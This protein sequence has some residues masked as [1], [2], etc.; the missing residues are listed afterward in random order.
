MSDSMKH[1]LAFSFFPVSAPPSSGGEERLFHIFHELSKTHKVTLLSSGFLGG[2]E[3]RVQHGANFV[4]RRIPKDEHFTR[5][6]DRLQ[7]YA[8]KGDIS[9][10]CVG[11]CGR[12][13]TLLHRAYIEEYSQADVIVHNFPFTIGYDLFLGLDS[14]VRIYNS[15]NCESKLY[16]MLHDDSSSSFIPDLV[17][18]L[19][20][21]LL[22]H[23]DCVLYCSETDLAEFNKIAPDGKFHTLSAPNGLTPKRTNAAS[24]AES[25]LSAVFIGSAHRPNVEAAQLLVNVVAPALPSVL[26]NIIGAC[27]PKGS[28]APNVRRHGV[29]TSEEKE[30][31]MLSADIAVN[32]M[33]A[34]SG[35][36]L[37]MLEFL[38]YGIPVISTKVGVRGLSLVPGKEYVLAEQDCFSERIRESLASPDQLA[39]VAER[40]Q[41]TAL[42]KYDWREI[43][44]PVAEF[45]SSFTKSCSFLEGALL[46]INDYNSFETIGGGGT[47]T[48]GL[49]KA[50]SEQSPVLF[51]CF[52][53]NEECYTQV[54]SDNIVSICIPKS[55]KLSRKIDTFDAMC[56]VS[57]AD[58][59]TARYCLNEDFF[60][61]VYNIV[62]R[63]AEMIQCE[64][65]YLTG[66]PMHFGDKFIYSSHNNEAALKRDL[67]KDHPEYELL[68]GTVEQ[69][70]KRAVENAAA[71]IATS[72]DDAF[73][74]TRG[75]SRGGPVWVLGNGA[76]VRESV[77]YSNLEPVVVASQRSV[78]FLG[79]AHMPNINA[80][81]K[82]FEEVV[83]K[84]PEITFHII[85]SVCS[86]LEKNKHRNVVLWG[87]LDEGKKNAVMA[88]CTLAVNPVFEGSGSNVKLADYIGSGLHV[89]CTPF[90]ARGYP[91]SVAEHITILPFDEFAKVIPELVET[92]TDESEADRRNRILYYNDNLSM[93][94]RSTKLVSFVKQ[95]RKKRKKV[96]A[97]TYRYSGT[98]LGGA[99]EHLLKL[100][101]YLDESGEFDIDVVSPEVTA[102]SSKF[103]FAE[104]YQYDVTCGA[105]IELQYTR[106]AR[107]PLQPPKD[108]WEKLRQAW[109]VQGLFEQKVYEKI[110][111]TSFCTRLAWGWGGCELS[112]SGQGTRWA[113]TS[114]GIH[115]GHESMLHIKAYTPRPLGLLVRDA[116]GVVLFSGRVEADFS[117]SFTGSAGLLEIVSSVPEITQADPRPL[118]FLL[119]EMTIDG[120]AYDLH[121]ETLTVL[122]RGDRE[123]FEIFSDASEQVRRSHSVS[124]TAMR[125]PHSPALEEFLNANV[126]EYDLVLTHNNIF[127]PAVAAVKAARQ[128]DVPVALLPHAHL[129]DDYYHFPDFLDS[130]LS[131]DLVFACPRAACDFFADRGASVCYHTPGANTEEVF[132]QEDIKAFRQIYPDSTPFFLV[133]GRKASAKGYQAVVAAAEKV[134]KQHACKIVLIGPDDDGVPVNSKVANYLGRQPRNVLRGALQSCIGVVNMSS[135]ESFG[136]VL[137]ESW[138]AGKPLIVNTGCAAFHDLAIDEENAL[139]VTE[140][141]LP[142]S[143]VRLLMDSELCCRLAQNGRDVALR[144]GWNGVGKTFVKQCFEMIRTSKNS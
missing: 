12:Y 104:D 36:S 28:Y 102:M 84:C 29:V 82:I 70:E 130:V 31:L 74:L 51:L 20:K 136:M 121:E 41:I 37:K 123:K 10:P 69:L 40:G 86:V 103:R 93:K 26:F 105:P 135:S 137:L 52:S 131:A 35:S 39:K 95:L 58:I 132:S 71:V 32:P 79:S 124:L 49:L 33:M 119:Q 50:I 57:S 1:I 47:R 83:P 107:F 43:V 134:A 46:A 80:V 18:D 48:Q 14:K 138:L 77:D 112:P 24:R 118:A 16:K 56:C 111:S 110:A 100:I 21:K 99:E 142:R 140:K 133:I 4:E 8:G 108:L 97:V 22:T 27:L 42:K 128:H 129:D 30:K 53:D 89:L 114:C 65:V 85:G 60:V 68:L 113:F 139:M 64:H 45:I 120:K 116:S 55:Q 96:L 23:A 66:I 143:M 3:E 61:D 144:Y 34:G 81:Q 13:L 106:F 122:D 67:L 115:L 126:K 109:L 54:I 91:D 125:G 9:G 98:P 117:L 62:K 63:K 127:R 38:S 17:L 11:A 76:H 59:V 92:F 101:T 2:V 73:S 5:E 44:K 78:V 90:G 87:I 15:E 88:S 7:Q 72:E 141:D 19:E 6:W 75:V 94:A 25:E